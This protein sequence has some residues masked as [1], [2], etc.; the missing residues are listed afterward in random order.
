LQKPL[1]VVVNGTAD[2]GYWAVHY[3]L[4]TGQ[5]SVRTTARRTD[6]ARVARLR[7]LDFAG[8]R[9]EIVPAALNDE[10]ALRA[11][12][13]G[14]QGIYGTSVYNIYAK[15]YRPANPE[16]REQCHAVINAARACSTLEHFVWQTM[17]RFELP[18]EELGL[19]TPIHFRTKW[20]FEDVIKD[21]GL[22]WT[23]LRQPPY[24]RQL[25]FGL[26]SRNRLV[27][28]YPPDTRLPF[29]AEQDLGKFVAAIFADRNS[30]LHQAVNGTSEVVTPAEIA[31]RAHRLMPA[32]NPKYRQASWLENA[33]FDYVI[34]G[35]KPAFRYP[36]QIN[37]NLM[38]GNYPA[39][40]ADDKARCARL[41]SPLPL[42][43]IEDWLRDYFSIAA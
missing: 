25:K 1:I 19:E 30:H 42:M 18:P 24:M 7:Q 5:F 23:F 9:C 11:A 38:A 20:H 16:E 35:L 12:F 29:V 3:L 28:P 34:V 10:A 40:N 21:I 4:Q 27:Y 6:S 41:V 32:F 26:R 36:S 15:R 22:P 2:E 33:F 37:A 43:T 31:A 39:M 14:A 13:A 8:N 17:T